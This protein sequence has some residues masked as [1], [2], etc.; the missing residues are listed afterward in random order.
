MADTKTVWALYTSTPAYGCNG[1][2]LYKTQR[3]AYESLLSYVDSDNEADDEGINRDDDEEFIEWVE[4][5]ASES[6]SDWYISEVA[7]P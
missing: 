1:I 6:G 5:V 4:E 7:L 2:E 3:E